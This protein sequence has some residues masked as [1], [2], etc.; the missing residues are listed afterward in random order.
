MPLESWLRPSCSMRVS[1]C[2][3]CTLRACPITATPV[4]SCGWRLHADDAIALMEMAHPVWA[5]YPPPQS[6]C[7]AAQAYPKNL[8]ENLSK[9]HGRNAQ[10][11]FIFSSATSAAQP[12]PVIFCSSISSTRANAHFFPPSL[13]WM[14]CHLKTFFPLSTL[15]FSCTLRYTTFHFTWTLIRHYYHV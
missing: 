12:S 10:S 8:R 11:H 13:S 14:R 9:A 3:Q 6:R 4:I 5:K 7:K 2:R 1:I 15:L